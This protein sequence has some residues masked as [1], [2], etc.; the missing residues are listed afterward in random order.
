MGGTV[1]GTYSVQIDRSVQNQTTTEGSPFDYPAQTVLVGAYARASALPTWTLR[2]ALGTSISWWW[3]TQ[4]SDH[5]LNLPPDEL[6][7]FQPS[8]FMVATVS[9]GVEARLSST[10][11]VIADVP[12]FMRV[13]GVVGRKA[14]SGIDTG[15]ETRALPD[16]AMFGFGLQVGIQ[17]RML[18]KEKSG[19]L[20]DYID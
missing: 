9:P 4:I 1:S 16:V 5:D 17:V 14:G 11:E 10:V 7:D 15:L 6:P 20:D 13:G 8:R 12:I 18:G 2:P 3:G 19:G